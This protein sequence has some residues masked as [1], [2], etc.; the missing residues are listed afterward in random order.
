[1]KAQTQASGTSEPGVA[2]GGRRSRERVQSDLASRGVVEE[3]RDALSHLLHSRTRELDE[4]GYARMLDGA[5]LACEAL[6]K[7]Q[8]G[9]ADSHREL[10]EM[11]RLIGAFSGELCKI[12]EILEVLAAYARRMR[13]ESS[14]PVPR[15][16][17]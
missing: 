12:D 10:R 8:P 2:D 3:W 14:A 11:E 15:I 9:V 5:T 7:S 13:H 1:M 6:E 4:D 17:H 16:L